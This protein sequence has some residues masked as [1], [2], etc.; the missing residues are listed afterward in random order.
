M[1]IRKEPVSYT[2]LDAASD[3]TGMIEESI[4][5]VKSG[6][7]I[8]DETA[9]SLLSVVNESHLVSENVREIREAAEEQDVY[10]RQATVS[11]KF[12]PPTAIQNWAAITLITGLPS[13]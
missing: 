9:Q 10:K 12:F 4:L 13:G 6:A 5:A 11:S 8:A 1:R 7:K 3:T 2:H